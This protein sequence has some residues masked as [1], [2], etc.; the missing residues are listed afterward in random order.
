MTV[1]LCFVSTIVFSFHKKRTTLCSNQLKMYVHRGPQQKMWAWFINKFPR[2]MNAKT[3]C[4]AAI[5]GS[6]NHVV[7]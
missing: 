3:L 6:S 2:V 5:V 7:P 1:K 4:A